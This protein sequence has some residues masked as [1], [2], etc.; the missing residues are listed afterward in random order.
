[1]KKKNSCRLLAMLL[2]LSLLTAGCAGKAG[3][4]GQT[5]DP[6]P[7]ET[8]TGTLDEVKDF[9]FVVV[10]DQGAAYAFPI[11]AAKPPAGLAEVETGD[12]VTVTYTGQLSEVDGFAGEIFSVEKAET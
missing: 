1:M 6:D 9:M 4:S 5:P 12:S 11:D 10:D 3:D 8:L 2:V 7:Q